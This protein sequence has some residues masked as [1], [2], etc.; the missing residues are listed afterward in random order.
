MRT[1]EIV[2]IRTGEVVCRVE[3]Q[4]Y[5]QSTF[6]GDTRWLFIGDDSAQLQFVGNQ[7]YYAV[8][9]K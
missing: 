3:A 7:L 8:Q 6:E 5:V 1:W 9:P 4:D 2:D